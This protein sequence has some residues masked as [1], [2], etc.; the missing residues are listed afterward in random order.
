[1]KRLWHFWILGHEQRYVVYGIKM[2]YIECRCG[3]IF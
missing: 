2:Y 1:M 3:R